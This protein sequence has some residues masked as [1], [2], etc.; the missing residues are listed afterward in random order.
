MT[1]PF[2]SSR[3]A[4]SLLVK[5][6]QT[7]LYPYLVSL[8]FKV[9]HARDVAPRGFP[10]KYY[11][12]RN[13]RIDVIF[14]QWRKWGAPKFIIDFNI[15][16][17]KQRFTSFPQRGSE[18]WYTESRYRAQR[19]KGFFEFWFGLTLLRRVFFPAAAASR[20]V[21]VTK[22][23]IGEID[24]FMSHGEP[25]EYLRDMRTLEKLGPRKWPTEISVS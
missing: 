6:M 14:F 12:V 21:G 17:D 23:R 25:S 15:I 19:N 5:E 9:F 11:R 4:K 13:D 3:D 2:L 10:T 8:G 22:R 20:T 18:S 1:L 24:R 16:E 7:H